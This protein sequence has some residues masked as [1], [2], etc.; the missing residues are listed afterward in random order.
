VADGAV[1]NL[2]AR[3]QNISAQQLLKAA[4]IRSDLHGKDPDGVIGYFVVVT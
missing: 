4:R 2:N 3:R 1:A